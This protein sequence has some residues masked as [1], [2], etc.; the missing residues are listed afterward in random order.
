MSIDLDTVRR[1]AALARLDLGDEELRTLAG[2]LDSILGYI[3]QLNELDTEGVE[4]LA[5]PLPV[6]NIFRA[7]EESP[8]LA[9]DA[10][11]ANA[12]SRSGDF[13]AV[14]AVLD[15]PEDSGKS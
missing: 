7:D 5:H 15:G 3:D 8:S 6:R 14:P 9:V 11:L 13:F 4:E 10:A 1:V 12:P 2:Q